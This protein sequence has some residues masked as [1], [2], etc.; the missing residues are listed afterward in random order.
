MAKTLGVDVSTWNGNIDWAKFKQQGVKFAIIR[1]GFG[2]DVSQEDT[3][4]KRNITEAYKQGI[5]VGIY[6][7]GYCH[8]VSTAKLEADACN[9]IISPY[10]SYIT[11]P[12]FFDWEY[13]SY[14]YVTNNG[15]CTPTKKLV[16]DMTIAFM[17]K[18]QDYGYKAGYYTNIDYMTRF[19]DYDR[20]KSYNL[21]LAQWGVSAPDS[22]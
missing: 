6:W 3:Q 8:S 10:K 20:I 9:T 5:A 1:A 17:N 19:Y 14:N 2:S 15:L 22:S 13:D 16:T 21:W 11:L 7:F 4:F 18:M 12:V